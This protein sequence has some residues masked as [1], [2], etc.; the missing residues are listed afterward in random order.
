M[1]GIRCIM[2]YH[3][4]NNT[5]EKVVKYTKQASGLMRVSGP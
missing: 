3:E 2:V 1:Q 5:K 4:N